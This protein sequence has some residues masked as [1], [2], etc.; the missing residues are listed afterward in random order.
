[1]TELSIDTMSV[2]QLQAVL[3]MLSFQRFSINIETRKITENP[4]VIKV[5]KAL[6]KAI[7]D[8]IK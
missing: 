6:D 8:K 2:E 3:N 7:I 5:Q 4:E 1:M